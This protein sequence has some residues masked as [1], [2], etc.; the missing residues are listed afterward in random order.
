MLQG[1]TE[2]AA[3]DQKNKVAMET[4]HI[5]SYAQVSHRKPGSC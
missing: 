2:S 5:Q 1:K 3:E 4:S